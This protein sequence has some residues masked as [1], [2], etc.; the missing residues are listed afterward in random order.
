MRDNKGI[1]HK[2]ILDGWKSNEMKIAVFI[3]S[4]IIFITVFSSIIFQNDPIKINIKD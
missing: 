4:F 2:I 3:L 1:F